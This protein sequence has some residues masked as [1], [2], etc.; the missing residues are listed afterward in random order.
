MALPG[1]YDDG[2]TPNAERWFDG[3]AWTGHLRP[4]TLAPQWAAPQGT[5]PWTAQPW[6]PQPTAQPWAPQGT[7]AA[8]GPSDAA[9]WLLP[10]GRSWQSITAGYVGL[11]GLVIWRVAP[12]AL[13][14]GIWAL[15]LAGD[16]GHGRGRAIFAI[17]AGALGTVVG[18]LALAYW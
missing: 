3:A 11:F 13:W 12:I 14:L 7:P 8:T 18:A 10:V 17:I 5:Q 6:S 16:G 9:Y 2:V 1:W 4:R 15:R